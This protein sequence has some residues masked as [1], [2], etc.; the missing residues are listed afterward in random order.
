M[1]LNLYFTNKISTLLLFALPAELTFVSIGLF[2]PKPT[3]LNLSAE[4]FL[5][6]KQFT[7][8]AALPSER[9]WLNP[10]VPILSVCPS[11]LKLAVG[12]LRIIETIASRTG[13]VPSVNVVAPNAN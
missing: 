11:T 10:F 4:I 13:G 5:P 7:T 6:D 1:C 3:A 9:D 8:A 12:Y 2:S